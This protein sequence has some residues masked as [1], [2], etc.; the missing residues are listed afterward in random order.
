MSAARWPLRWHAPALAGLLLCPWLLVASARCGDGT[1][2]TAAV[3]ADHAVDRVYFGGGYALFKNTGGGNGVVG[4]VW[5]QSWHGIHPGISAGFASHARFVALSGSYTWTLGSR[6]AVTLGTGP[7][8]YR[9][10]GSA[11]NLG[12]PLEFLS[13]LAISC[14]VGHDHRV[15]LAVGHISNANLAPYNP[16][17]NLIEILYQV[18][19]RQ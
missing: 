5:R 6:F 10:E 1:T 14:R 11:P 12:S 13:T 4:F 7:G 9:R 19:L 3:A 18:P 16:G 8:I 17:A 2:A 15:A